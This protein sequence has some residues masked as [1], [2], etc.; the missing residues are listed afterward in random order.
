MGKG[1]GRT[2]PAEHSRLSGEETWQGAEQKKGA[3]V[4]YTNDKA[5]NW[6]ERQQKPWPLVTYLLPCASK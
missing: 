3:F 2:G 4:F 6:V 5:S 1:F